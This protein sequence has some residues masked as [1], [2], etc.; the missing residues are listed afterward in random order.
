MSTDASIASDGLRCTFNRDE[1]NTLSADEQSNLILQIKARC[2]C[3]VR[4]KYG[5]VVNDTTPPLMVSAVVELPSLSLTVTMS[6]S[7]RQESGV[8]LE[9]YYATGSII[10]L[11]VT[12]YITSRR[13]AFSLPC[14]VVSRLAIGITTVN[15][16]DNSTRDLAGNYATISSIRLTEAGKSLSARIDHTN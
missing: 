11:N 15:L 12:S 5:I 4:N 14:E 6:E 16:K 3:F 7:I 9:I 2:E 1:V 13:L 10:L 8:Q